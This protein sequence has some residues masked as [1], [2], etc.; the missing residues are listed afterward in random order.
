MVF[1]DVL[2]FTAASA[3]AGAVLCGC[4]GDDNALLLPP[5]A[6]SAD[7]HS[8]AA[9]PHDGA[10]EA[11]ADAGSA[12]DGPGD[13]GAQGEAG[14]AASTSEAGDDAAAVDG[15]AVSD[16]GDAAAD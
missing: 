5:D 14:G 6:S 11:S 1:I 2:R 10:A 8:D 13:T 3:L 9:A 4:Q 16:A 15:V 7:A 12:A